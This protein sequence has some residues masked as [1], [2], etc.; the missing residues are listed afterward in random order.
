M[1]QGGDHTTN[2][3]MPTRRRSV[4]V[5]DALETTMQRVSLPRARR[6]LF[7]NKWRY[8]ATWMAEKPCCLRCGELVDDHP[9]SRW[10]GW[11]C[12]QAALEERRQWQTKADGVCVCQGCGEHF[13]VNSTTSKYC[14]N[15]CRQRAYRRRKARSS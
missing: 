9:P 3:T 12:Q 6:L 8:S 1:T 5:F 10:C 11:G 2:D 13:E 4:T 15:V 7:E 14:D